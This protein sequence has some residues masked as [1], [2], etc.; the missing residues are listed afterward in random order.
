MIWCI[1]LAIA[2]HVFQSG[3]RLYKIDANP[4]TDLGETHRNDSW[5]PEKADCSDSNLR[6]RGTTHLEGAAHASSEPRWH[7]R[8]QYL[9]FASG[10]CSVAGGW[11]VCYQ[12]HFSSRFIENLLSFIFYSSLSMR[13]LTRI[14]QISVT[15][16]KRL[17]YVRACSSVHSRVRLETCK[18]WTG[19]RSHCCHPV[20]LVHRGHGMSRSESDMMT[21]YW[22]RKPSEYFHAYLYRCHVTGAMN[23]RDWNRQS[24]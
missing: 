16:T 11:R 21:W 8:V 3:D 20:P 19:A 14:Q 15:R 5:V 18:S 1:R 9:C 17:D 10:D 2:C 13:F 24:L 6:S 4:T 12:N 23:R 7:F 22:L